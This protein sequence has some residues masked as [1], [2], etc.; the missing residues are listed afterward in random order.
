[1]VKKI[2]RNLISVFLFV[3]SSHSFAVIAFLE[4]CNFKY[5]RG[6]GNSVYV[7]VY[8]SAVNEDRF[9]RTFKSYCP[10]AIKV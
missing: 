9:T 7:G 1:M 2:F 6:W 8:K 4:S 5:I 10:E 3:F